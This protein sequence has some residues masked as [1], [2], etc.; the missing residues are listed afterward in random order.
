MTISSFDANL[1]LQFHV[2]REMQWEREIKTKLF[3]TDKICS[4]Y[5]MWNGQASDSYNYYSG[6]CLINIMI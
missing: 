1:D 6:A 3:P 4:Q 5:L 2:A